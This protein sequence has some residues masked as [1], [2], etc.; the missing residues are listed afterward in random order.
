MSETLHQICQPAVAFF[1]E[2][3]PIYISIDLG[4]IGTVLTVFVLIGLGITLF[5]KYKL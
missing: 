2:W 1:T 4:P 5:K 3:L